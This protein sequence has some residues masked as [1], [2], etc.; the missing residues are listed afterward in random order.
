MCS[1]ESAEHLSQFCLLQETPSC[2]GRVKKAISR[3]LF[4]QCIAAKD[5]Q[6]EVLLGDEGIPLALFIY[7]FA[8]KD[9]TLTVRRFK[10]LNGKQ[11]RGE[12]TQRY[13]LQ[14][15][16]AITAEKRATKVII[17]LHKK[18]SLKDF[19]LNRGFGPIPC[20]DPGYAESY[21]LFRSFTR[22]ID[23]GRRGEKRERLIQNGRPVINGRR[24]GDSPRPF[25][26]KSEYVSK[27]RR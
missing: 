13:L 21:E 5:R 8:L 9:E 23:V 25:A 17:D 18:S 2:H 4:A 11:N 3:T 24:W 22:D 27:K 12:E 7:K 16:A 20:E 19:L 10:V 14:R 1:K 6:R 15:I 26:T